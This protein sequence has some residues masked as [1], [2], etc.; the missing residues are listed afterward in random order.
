MT[1]PRV[2]MHF[3]DVRKRVIR[4]NN[5]PGEPLA[6]DRLIGSLINQASLAEGQGA[7]EELL[8]ELVNKGQSFSGRGN[9][10]IGWGQGKRLGTGRWKYENGEWIKQEQGSA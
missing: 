6:K 2:G 10:Q 5:T 1:L 7:K 3:E 9:K 8:K 4:I